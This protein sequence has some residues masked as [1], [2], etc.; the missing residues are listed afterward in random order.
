MTSMIPAP[1]ELPPGRHAEI[2]AALRRDMNRRRLRFAPIITAVAALSV[3]GLVAFFVPWRPEAAPAVLPPPAPI[4]ATP[5]IPELSPAEQAAIAEGC[6]ES[7]GAVGKPVLYNYVSTEDTKHA[8]VYT[9]DTALPCE[10]DGPNIKYN[11]GLHGRL[12]LSWLPGAFAIDHLGASAGGDASYRHPVYRGKL[13]SELAMGRIT[14][15]VARL[16]LTSG[17]TTVEAVLA[18]GTFVARIL[19]PTDWSPTG[20]PSTVIRAYDHDGR[21][22]KTTERSDIYC[23]ATPDGTIITE[24]REKVDPKTCEPATRWR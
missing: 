15:D 24:V 1:R 10:I 11:S 4:P 8:L 9:E 22:L 17:S 3:I 19:H 14:P 6:R 18:N 7:A 23:Y 2:R 16:T 21:L 13:G 5:V 20:V 12:P